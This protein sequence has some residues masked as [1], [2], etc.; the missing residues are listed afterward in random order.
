MVQRTCNIKNK[1]QI[2]VEISDDQ[3]LIDMD[4]RV[5][6]VTSFVNLPSAVIVVPC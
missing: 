3:R 4:Q 5:R 1:G 6:D 2:V